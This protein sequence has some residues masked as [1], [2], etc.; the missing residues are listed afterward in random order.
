[1][2]SVRRPVCGTALTRDRG[3]SFDS[4]MRTE[5][6]SNAGAAG[7]CL[8]TGIAPMASGVTIRSAMKARGRVTRMGGAYYRRYVDHV[9]GDSPLLR[10]LHI[11]RAKQ[12]VQ[13]KHNGA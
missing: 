10:L 5:T 7:F 13:L 8:A 11:A 9:G 2:V 1:P 3:R 4:L 12:T 6:T